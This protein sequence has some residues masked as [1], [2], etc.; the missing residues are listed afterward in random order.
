MYET[1]YPYSY[2]LF[3]SIEVAYEYIRNNNLNKYV[4]PVFADESIYPQFKN[5]EPSIIYKKDK[6]WKILNWFKSL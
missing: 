6:E 4:R 3:K 2:D 1:E 5:T